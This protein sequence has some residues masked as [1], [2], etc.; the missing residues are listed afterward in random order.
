LS[1]YSAAIAAARAS[2]AHGA[3]ESRGGQFSLT[4]GYT[5]SY[6]PR[7]DATPDS[8]SVVAVQSAHGPE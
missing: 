1:G 7:D 2:G 6:R 8:V 3:D 5:G 4:L